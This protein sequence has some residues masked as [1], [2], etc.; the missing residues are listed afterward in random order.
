MNTQ[1]SFR[2]CL[3]LMAG[4]SVTA[5]AVAQPVNDLCEDATA[6]SG[7]AAFA[8]DSNGGG[9]DGAAEGLCN[10]FGSNQIYNDLWY[11]WTADADGPV[12]VRTCD[13][14][15]LDTKIAVYAGCGCPALAPIACNDDACGLQSEV[16]W[17]AVAGQS[18]MIRVGSY[19][20]FDFDSGE[21][22]VFSNVLGII[23]GPIANP[24][25]GSEY[26]LLESSTWTDAEARAVSLGGHLA[27]VDDAA[28]NEFLRAAVLGFDGADRRGW[29]GLN[30]FATE[31]TFVWSSGAP[32]NFTNWNPG[33]PNDSGGAED[34]VEMFGSN[35]EWNDNANSPGGLQVFGLVEIEGGSA[36]PGDFDDSGDIG[37]GDLTLLLS[38]F[39]TGSGATVGDMDGDGDVDLSDLTSFLSLFGSSCP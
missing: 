22:E 4:A 10:F 1:L 34:A 2:N 3:G 5:M 8:F 32:V 39:G 13:R 26:Y 37:L 14:T 28:E 19:D 25:N 6:I 11:C 12:G 27:T 15:G 9:T 17:A 38:Q 20:L 24:A 16:T 31:G 33:E 7:F 23:T 29:I 30:D 18:Y 21:I 35:G 36:C